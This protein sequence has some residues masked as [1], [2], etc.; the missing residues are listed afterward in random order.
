MDKPSLRTRDLAQKAP[1]FSE[2]FSKRLSEVLVKYTS[3][4]FALP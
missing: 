4:G 3:P 1:Y 2:P